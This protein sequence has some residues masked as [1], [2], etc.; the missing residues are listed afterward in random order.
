VFLS[1]LVA[2]AKVVGVGGKWG[3]VA[4]ASPAETIEDVAVTA[5]LVDLSVLSLLTAVAKIVFSA[6]QA[7]KEDVG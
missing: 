5:R 2:R 1:R 6:M 3:H 4:T 7:V